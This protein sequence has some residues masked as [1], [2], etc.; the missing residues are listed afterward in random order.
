[1]KT[2][3]ILTATAI[4]FFLLFTLLSCNKGGDDLLYSSN[5]HMVNLSGYNNSEEELILQLDT[6]AATVTPPFSRIEFGAKSK[7]TDKILLQREIKASDTTLETNLNVI[8]MDG[9]VADFPAV[10]AP[11]EG[12]VQLIYMLQS[13]IL[14]YREPVDIVFG[15]FYFTPKVFEEVIRIKNLKPN[16]FSKPIAFDP[17]PLGIQDYNGQKTSVLFRAYIYKAG[18]DIPYSE[19]S[20]YTF[21]Q[22]TSGAPVPSPTTSISKLFIINEAPLNNTMRFNKVLE[23]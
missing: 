15:K 20:S 11:V 18:T 3:P 4:Y 16:E 21:N 5:V 17:F 12:K 23:L 6:F 1:M 8:Y 19:G 10:P 2:Q 22:L 9:K 14:N 7:A 13:N